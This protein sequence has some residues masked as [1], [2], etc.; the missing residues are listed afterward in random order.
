MV[1][2]VY[3]KVLTLLYTTFFLGIHNFSHKPRMTLG[4]G[5]EGIQDWRESGGICAASTVS[6]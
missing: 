2:T 6:G 4:N 1:R 3:V 5:D